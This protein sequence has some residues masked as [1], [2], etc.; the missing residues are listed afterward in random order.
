MTRRQ[1]DSAGQTL[2]CRPS[3]RLATASAQLLLL[4][5]LLLLL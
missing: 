5:L 1:K 4:L 3:R 2:E